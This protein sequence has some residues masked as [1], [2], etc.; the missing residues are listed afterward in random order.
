MIDLYGK[1]TA[2]CNQLKFMN[3]TSFVGIKF[4]SLFLWETSNVY[5]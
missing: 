5:C 4:S 1:I 2:I 3:E